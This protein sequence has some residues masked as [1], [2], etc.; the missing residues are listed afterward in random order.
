MVQAW[1]GTEAGWRVLAMPLS[2]LD[3]DGQ[4]TAGNEGSIEAYA[5]NRILHKMIS[6]VDQSQCGYKLVDVH[7]GV[8]N[9]GGGGSSSSSSDDDDDDSEGSD[10]DDDNDTSAPMTRMMR[11]D[12]SL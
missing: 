3:D 2:L 7:G 4:V 10:E 1:K 8:T 9:G 11:V 12:W 5:I 6:K